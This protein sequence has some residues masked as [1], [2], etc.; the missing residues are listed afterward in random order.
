M[1]TIYWQ[2]RLIVCFLFLV[3]VGLGCLPHGSFAQTGTSL[4]SLNPAIVSPIPFASLNV[5]GNGF[6]AGGIVFIALYDQWGR[7]LEET[8]WTTAS[9]ATYGANGSMDPVQGY[10]TGGSITEVFELFR[11]TT[12]GPNGSMDPALGYR[13]G[14]DVPMNQAIYGANGSQDPAQGYVGQDAAKGTCNAPL[15]VRAYDQHQATWTD[16]VDA[17]FG[18]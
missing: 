3:S 8:R 10:A 6:T 17:T 15:M 4:P 18:C 13:A 14:V 9:T 1:A 11:E 2:N 16:P 12:Y 7:T 5:T